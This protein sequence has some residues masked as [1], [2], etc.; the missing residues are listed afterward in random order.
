VAVPLL[1]EPEADQEVE[2]ATVRYADE[3]SAWVGDSSMKLR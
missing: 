1:I 3:R 2:A